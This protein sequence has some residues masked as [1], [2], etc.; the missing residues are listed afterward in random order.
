MCLA[1][2]LDDAPKIGKDNLEKALKSVPTQE[3]I[4]ADLLL[5]PPDFDVKQSARVLQFKNQDLWL[6]D[7]DTD[8]HLPILVTLCETPRKIGDKGVTKHWRKTWRRRH[9]TR[10]ILRRRRRKRKQGDKPRPPKQP[11]VHNRGPTGNGKTLGDHHELRMMNG[12]HMILTIR[13]HRLARTLGS[14]VRSRVEPLSTSG[15]MNKVVISRVRLDHRDT[16]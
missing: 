4:M 10:K 11:G 16:S 12:K 13:S 1:D 3:E 7:R 6:K 8:W 5:A 9:T 14:S 2:L 15:R